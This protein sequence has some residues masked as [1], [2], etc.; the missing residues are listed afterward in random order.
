MFTD[1]HC[2]LDELENIPELIARAKE[3]QVEI[4]F[5]NSVDLKSMQAN[6]KLGKQFS[7]IKPLLGLHPKDILKMSD[8]EIEI[9]LKFIEK[10]LK[11]CA[12]IGEI[13]LDYKYAE[14]GTQQQ[15]QQ[16]IFEQQIQI[17]KE[18]DLAIE[19]HSRRAR[20]QCLETL[21]KM[22]AEKVLLHWF[23]GNQKQIQII[24]DHNWFVSIGASIL[25][26]DYNHEVIKALELEHLLIETDTP[27]PFNGQNSEP[28]WIRKIAEK[29]AEIK[30][31]SLKEIEKT[32]WKNTKKLFKI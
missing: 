30:E 22:N 18:N 23:N 17:A 32:T 15:K 31:I 6:L 28:A 21:K 5:S 14:T 29:I 4:M 8:S 19:V 24:Q 10:N 16:T 1:I 2:H 26:Q 25:F 12:G 11:N 7:E 9:G 3:N 27:V 13:G 20:E